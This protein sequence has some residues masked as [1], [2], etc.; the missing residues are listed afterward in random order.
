MRK[1][2]HNSVYEFTWRV[3]VVIPWGILFFT[4]SRMLFRAVLNDV[5]IANTLNV[6][7]VFWLVIYLVTR[8]IMSR[9]SIFESVLIYLGCMSLFLAIVN[10]VPTATSSQLFLG[11]IGALMT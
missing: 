2:I 10:G 3:C 4:D 9:L 5:G 7:L 11:Y 1:V 8:Y 6:I